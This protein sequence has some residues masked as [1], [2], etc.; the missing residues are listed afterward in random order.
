ME[1][2][3]IFDIFILSLDVLEFLKKYFYVMKLLDYLNLEILC[4]MCYYYFFVLG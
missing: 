4:V 2:M 3:K 1:E